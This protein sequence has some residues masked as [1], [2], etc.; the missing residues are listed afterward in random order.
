MQRR[1]AVMGSRD[2]GIGAHAQPDAGG[3]QR[4]HVM[5]KD[6]PALTPLRGGGRFLGGIGANGSDR[7]GSRRGRS[8]VL[9]VDDTPRER[10]H[11]FTH[12][13]FEDCGE[14]W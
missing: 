10:K 8:S 2:A 12:G 6:L 11:R 14:Q 1:P 7:P 3:L 4:R 9:I 5:E 13:R